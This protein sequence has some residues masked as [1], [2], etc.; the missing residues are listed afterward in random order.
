[1]SIS[2]APRTTGVLDS[3]YS[4]PDRSQVERRNRYIQ[5][6]VQKSYRKS[7]DYGVTLEPLYELNISPVTSWLYSIERRIKDSIIPDEYKELVST[8]WLS[9]NVG[10]AA[11]RFFENTADLLPKEPHIY[12][13][14]SG[15][16]VAEFETKTGLL[17]TVIS[18]EESILFGTNDKTPE[19]TFEITVKQGSNRLRE[20]LKE[21]VKFVAESNG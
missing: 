8:E 2:R 3:D 4:V 17:T 20:D 13:S 5:R 9:E 6:L 10:R 7:S 15:A 1:M 12:A 19:K 11:V 16:L 21:V 14:Q 18:P